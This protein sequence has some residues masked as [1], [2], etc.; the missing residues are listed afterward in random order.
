MCTASASQT[1]SVVTT[2]GARGA[3]VAWQD[4]RFSRVNIFAQHVL[5]SGEVDAAWPND[6]RALLS[7]P[8]AMA[9]AEG[10][11]SSPVIVA[12]GAGG[13]IVAWLDQRSSVSDVDIFAQHVLASGVVDPPGP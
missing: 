4:L 1:H 6:G 2:D 8:L 13:A 12:D 3:I 7:D 10:G 9:G 11:Q 5:A